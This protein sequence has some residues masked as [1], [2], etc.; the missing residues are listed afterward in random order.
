MKILLKNGKTGLFVKN[1]GDW[2]SKAEHALNFKSPKAADDYRQAHRFFLAS[3]LVRFKN[4]R[5][6]IEL[7]QP[8]FGSHRASPVLN[9]VTGACA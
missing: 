9:G 7:K 4:P 1:S 3:V 2:T 8:V 6:D 5:H